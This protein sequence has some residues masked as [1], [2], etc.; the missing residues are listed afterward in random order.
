MT[1]SMPTP[2]THD[3]LKGLVEGDA[4]AIRGIAKLEPAGGPE[5]KVFPPTHSV[6]GKKDDDLWRMRPDDRRGIKYAFEKRRIKGVN[7]DCVLIDSVQSQANRMEEAPS[8]DFSCAVQ[9]HGLSAGAN[10][11]R[12]LSLQPVA[13]GAVAEVTKRLKPLV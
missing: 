8:P 11:A 6:R 3:L 12:Q 7:V 1:D 9:R 5:D 10:P 4:V 2:L 13:I